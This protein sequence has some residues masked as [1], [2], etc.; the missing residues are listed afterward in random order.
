MDLLNLSINEDGEVVT[1]VYVFEG[2]SSQVMGLA[3]ASATRVI[4]NALMQTEH[5]SVG[6]REQIEADIVHYIEEGLR[7]G[8]NEE[9][10][11]TKRE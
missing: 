3:L 10:L 5:L 7:E 8:G 6:A 11:T 4:A 2:V 9:D 1:K